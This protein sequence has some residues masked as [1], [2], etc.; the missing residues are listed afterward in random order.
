LGGDAPLRDISVDFLKR[1]LETPPGKFDDQIERAT[2]TEMGRDTQCGGLAEDPFGG[3][4]SEDVFAVN[5][6]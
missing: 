3:V 5:I 4:K 1:L 2:P 6:T